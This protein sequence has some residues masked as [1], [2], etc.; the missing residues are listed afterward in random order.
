MCVPSAAVNRVKLLV[1]PTDVLNSCVRE[2]PLFHDLTNS[3]YHQSGK[4]QLFWYMCG[5]DLP[6]FDLQ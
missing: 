2:F 4:F 3:Q 1:V 5:F 6:F